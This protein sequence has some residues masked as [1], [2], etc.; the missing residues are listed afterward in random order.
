MLENINFVFPISA[1]MGSS[2]RWGPEMALWGML[3]INEAMRTVLTH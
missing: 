3:Q 1:S 2:S